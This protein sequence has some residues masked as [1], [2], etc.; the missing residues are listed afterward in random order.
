MEN[1]Q[2]KT[3]CLVTWGH[4]DDVV[5]DIQLVLNSYSGKGWRLVSHQTPREPNEGRTH[6]LIF[7]APA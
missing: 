6:I 4:A 7:E 2:Y 5:K 3:E 1:Y